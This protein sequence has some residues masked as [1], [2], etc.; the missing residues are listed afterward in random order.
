MGLYVKVKTGG[1]W[2]NRK[3][4]N[5]YGFQS[6]DEALEQIPELVKEMNIDLVTFIES[7]AHKKQTGWYMRVIERQEFE[8][9]K[10]EKEHKA[11]RQYCDETETGTFSGGGGI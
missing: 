7:E 1:R 9:K 10:L 3:I 2:R 11:L 6:V 4:A 5:L 8:I